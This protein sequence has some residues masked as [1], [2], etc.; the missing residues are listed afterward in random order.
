M[1]SSNYPA[2]FGTGTGGQISVVTKSGGNQLRGSVFEYLR[3]SSLDAR[4]FFDGTEKTPLR[5]NQYGGSVG[6]PLIKER[7]RFFAA[8]EGLKQRAGV[9]LV[10]TVHS[11]AARARAVASI[12]PLLAGYPT[13]GTATSN[14]DLDLVRVSAS[15]PIDEDY[16]SFRLDCRLSDKDIF[17]LR[18]S[19]NQ[20]YLQSPLDVSGSY[21]LVTAVPQNAVLNYQ[22][23]LLQ[24]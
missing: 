4:N 10:A 14:P 12:R 6:G 7:L 13:G 23:S 16:G 17:Y 19:R 3:N 24:R 21:S 9:N 5:L 22:R 18:Y 2:E 15:S 11:A 8:Y 20:G 1:E